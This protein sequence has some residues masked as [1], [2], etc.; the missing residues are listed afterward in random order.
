MKNERKNSS[1]VLILILV[2]MGAF[3]V[4]GGGLVAPGLPTI[5]NAFNVP[6][7]QE[8]LILSIYTLSAALALPLIG[9]LIDHIGRREIGIG[10]LLLDGSAGLAIIFSPNFSILLL[11]RFLQGIGIA[12][13]VPVAMTV[14]GDIYSGKNRLKIMG[15]LS[16]TI[17][18][19]AAVIPLLG[20]YLASI[21]WTLIFVI[22][23]FSLVLA[24]L[25]FYRLP[26]TSSDSMMEKKNSQSVIG[27]LI[28]L[29]KVF[30]IKKI[31]NIMIHS[32]M[33]Y[34]LLYALVTYLPIFLVRIHEFDEIFNGLA[35]SV[36]AV[37][38]AILASRASF[39]DDYLSWRKRSGLGF[40]LIGLCFLLLP[41]WPKGSYLISFSF[42][43]FGI[44]MGIVSPTI[45]NRVT[46]LSPEELSGSVISIFN[47]MKYVGM[48]TA[49][50]IIGLNLIY[51]ELTF[52]FIVVGIFSMI[53][54]INTFIL[55]IF[56][57]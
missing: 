4:M 30:K 5:G 25:L 41:Y 8:G 9:Y 18:L 24:L 12:G 15:Y 57:K 21:D 34:F 45:Y 43:I 54:A 16:G 2:M 20:G 48:T 23:G 19:G 17:S 26:E 56:K 38:S 36:Q 52:I 27:Y 22:Y 13:L 11:L 35:L 3:G 46:Y 33:L 50:F 32:F 49:P 53:W 28:S 6:E 40:T 51:F 7:E 55:G 37:F 47:T 1:K 29:F 44:G 39:I 10:C 14:I 42:V 31:R